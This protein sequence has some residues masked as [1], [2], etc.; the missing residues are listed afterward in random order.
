MTTALLRWGIK[1]SLVTYIRQLNDG[2]ISTSG[3]VV[4]LADGRFEFAGAAD[5]SANTSFSGAVH[6]RGHA[7]MLSLD[8]VDP[9][10]EHD[11]GHTFL[12]IADQDE[13]DGRGRIVRLGGFSRATSLPASCTMSSELTAFGEGLFLANY[14][15]G[16]LF[17]PVEVAWL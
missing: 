14:R 5:D 9:R 12:T 2:S 13:P 7:G 4:A 1:S 17:D 15:A 8:I 3:N 10:V 16:M 6:L 11:L